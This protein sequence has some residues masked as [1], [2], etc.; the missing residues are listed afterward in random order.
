M[1]MKTWAARRQCR[2][3]E[4]AGALDEAQSD[5]LGRRWSDVASDPNDARVLARRAETLR[6][7]WREPIKDR[8]AFL[9][10]RCVGRSVLDIG[11]VAHDPARMQSPA[12]L[13]GRLAAV[14]SACIGVDVIDDGVQAMRELGYHAIVHDLNLGFEPLADFCPFDVIVAGE[15]IEHVE[16][17]DMLFKVAQTLLAERGQLILTTPNPY[18]PGRVHSGQRGV[19][20]ENVDHILYAFPSG[21]A[22][23]AERHDLLLVEATT[24]RVTR[25]SLAERARMLRRAIRG[26]QWMS[27]GYSTAGPRNVA[28]SGSGRGYRAARWRGAEPQFLGETSIYVVCRRSDETFSEVEASDP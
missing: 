11:C 12:W 20:W 27:L 1:E 14:A 8:T 24:T 7:A 6:A 9:V 19:V 5:A 21:I 25:S 15:V 18:A 16:A 28:R 13:H 23:L 2:A 22:E 26:R 4:F 10:E 3:K 17:L